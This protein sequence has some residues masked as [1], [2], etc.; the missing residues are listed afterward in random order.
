VSLKLACLVIVGILPTAIFADDSTSADASTSILN[1]YLT[2]SESQA[3]IMRGMQMDVDIDAKLPKLKKEGKLNALRFISQIG[4]I[5][6][7]MRSFVGDNTIKKDV[8]AR[9]LN[10]E[11]QAQL[12][13]TSLAITPANYKFKYKGLHRNEKQGMHVFQVTPIKKRI[14]LFKGELWI[15]AETYLPL[16]ESGRFVKNPSVFLKKVEFTRD[17]EIRDGVAIPRTIDSVIDTR[18]VGR[19]EIHIAYTNVTRQEAEP[20]SLAGADDNN[21][22]R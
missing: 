11:T 16:R 4:K 7:V 12:G 6:Y 18:L 9:Y 15:D 3:V 20:V 8:I 21:N 1:R 10:A 14:G 19:A 13:T 22:P 2:A 5:S 17:Y